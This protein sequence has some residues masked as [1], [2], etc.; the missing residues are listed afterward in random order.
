MIISPL[1]VVLW[2]PALILRDATAGYR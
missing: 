1:K 2:L